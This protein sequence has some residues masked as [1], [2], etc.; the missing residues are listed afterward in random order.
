MALWLEV[1][2]NTHTVIS[3][4]R[5]PTSSKILTFRGWEIGR[6]LVSED[7]ST[8]FIHQQASASYGKEMFDVQ[9]VTSNN[10]E[11]IPHPSGINV[12]KFILLPFIGNSYLKPKV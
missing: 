7:N 11:Y 12:K 4:I 9:V 3:P 2:C 10:A 5:H 8:D 6:R 1:P